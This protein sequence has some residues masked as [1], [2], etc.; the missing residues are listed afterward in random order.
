MTTLICFYAIVLDTI[1]VTVTRADS[2]PSTATLVRSHR[3]QER[4]GES[5][6]HTP[7]SDK[8]S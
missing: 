5:K 7:Q 8:R 1:G 2:R 6:T 3:A 4:R